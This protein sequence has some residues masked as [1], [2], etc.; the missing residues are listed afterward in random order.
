MVNY[1]QRSTKYFVACVSLAFVC[2]FFFNNDCLAQGDPVLRRPVPSWVKPV[3]VTKGEKIATTDVSNGYVYVLYDIQTNCETKETFIHQAR[4]ILNDKGV[5]NGSELNFDIDPSYEKC[6]F[7][8][9][10]VT[11][12]GVV[13]DRTKEVKFKSV[14]PE[15]RLNN[16]IYDGE[17]QA[18][19][20]LDDIRKG[21]LI[22]YAYSFSGFNPVFNGKFSRTM[23]FEGSDIIPGIY[24]R[25][26]ISEKRKL[27]LREYLNPP[28]AEISTSGGLTEYIWQ[29]ENIPAKREEARIPSWYE[30][31]TLVQVSEF[32]TW[33]ELKSWAEN[34]F[35]DATP[36]SKAL[37]NKLDEIRE[38]FPQKED[39]LIAV[40]RFVQNEIRYTGIE[41]GEYA[42]KPQ[43][44][45]TV[46]SQRY[47]DCKGK[48]VLFC[49]MLNELHIEAYP[50]LVDAYVKG[51][52]DELLPSPEDFNHCIAL[53]HFRDSA[54]WFDATATSQGGKLGSVYCPD[55]GKA[56]VIGDTNT[57]LTEIPS[58]Q[59][60]RTHAEE[61][62]IVGDTLQ[63]TKLFVT[64]TYTGE[65]ADQQ[66]ETFAGSSLD[67]IKEN[68]LN[69]Y[70]TIY[71]EISAVKSIQ[72]MDD[73]LNNVLVTVESY[74]IGKM[75]EKEDSTKEKYRAVF[76][77]AIFH[78]KFYD[79]GSVTR[80][81]P[82]GLA[83]PVDL[84]QTI[85]I[86]TPGRWNIIEEKVD[87]DYPWFKAGY[88]AAYS[89]D[90]VV[91][92]YKYKAISSF[93]PVADVP[94]YT[95]A[96]QKA[97]AN[98]NYSLSWN[99]GIAET[100]SGNINW[101]M[102]TL[103]IVFVVLFIV[104]A[105]II[106]KR[107]LPVENNFAPLPIGGW[108]FVVILG[109][110]LTP[111]RLF[112]EIVSSPFFNNSIWTAV[113][114]KASAAYHPLYGPLLTFELV[115][116]LFTICMAAFTLYLL[117][118]RRTI[119]PRAMIIYLS[120]YLVFL[121]IDS[122]MGNFIPAIAENSA[123]ETSSQTVIRSIVYS[124]IWIPYMLFSSRVKQTFLL[125]YG[126]SEDDYFVPVSPDS[127]VV[128]P[129]ALP[130]MPAELTRPEENTP[131]IGEKNK[132]A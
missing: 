91:L 36:S 42:H 75:W 125:T 126:K 101:T 77:A 63:L 76:S 19:A 29:K 97:T 112:V 52:V 70:G 100:N 28:K 114:D 60:G 10:T 43:A 50:A 16:H 111:L 86:V 6:I 39:Q 4:K 48:A 1:F 22:D 82:I 105:R 57:T 117:L 122:V 96:V 115:G 14:H 40:L 37:K 74:E 46:F 90:T 18:V 119:F 59:S 84:T 5:E 54:Y 25:I 44:A 65:D 31:N 61:L 35:A 13:M 80:T 94:A 107:D 69:Y 98:E 110:V 45:N 104:L 7:H 93:V 120:S 92:N 123:D 8:K 33:K 24:Q 68:Y 62:F 113:T 102:I 49:R 124:A 38:K 99:P 81:M 3:E 79:P 26:L 51:H 71:N 106:N 55:Y 95:S 20:F 32:G 27:N 56:L 2:F 108:L 131:D 21:D 118:G 64:T 41:T 34:L 15:S 17:I 11:R 132:D 12:D 87:S 109:L 66:R 58:S 73:T 83:Y 127:N 23:Y 121:L 53:V 78:E 9:L 47:G 116:N 30:A 129:A 85:K 72:V 88:E 128:E 103:S 89:G 130:T 67:E